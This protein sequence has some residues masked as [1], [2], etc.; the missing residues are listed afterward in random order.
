MKV[1][2]AR[3]EAAIMVTGAMPER[4]A[5]LK[6]TDEFKSLQAEVKAFEECETKPDYLLDESGSLISRQRIFLDRS[7]CTDE[8]GNP[9]VELAAEMLEECSDVLYFHQDDYS[10]GFF[11]WVMEQSHGEPCLVTYP[12]E[13]NSYSVFCRD[14][15]L[16][17]NRIQSE[18]H[19]LALV[20]Q[21]IRKNGYFP[22][23]GSTDQCG[24]FSHLTIPKRF[25][26]ATDAEL[27]AMIEE[28]EQAESA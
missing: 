11:E 2:D 18:E 5:A 1:T 15:D 8:E 27:S 20:E 21:A 9:D 10:Q 17:V 28:M 6:Q 26:D 25:V 7:L 23:V 14:L 12:N 13:R 19:G 24:F 3:I 16:K 22:D 4:I